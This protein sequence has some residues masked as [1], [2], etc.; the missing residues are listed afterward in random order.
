MSQIRTIDKALDWQMHLIAR[1][2]I[3]QNVSESK[4]I[5]ITEEMMLEAKAEARQAIKDYIAKEID[6]ARAE[7]HHHIKWRP[8]EAKFIESQANR[9]AEL[10]Q[11][12]RLEKE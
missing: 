11:R 7:E 5:N 8:S 12:Q 2:S 10:A 6:K 3:L 1:E 9:L 4:K